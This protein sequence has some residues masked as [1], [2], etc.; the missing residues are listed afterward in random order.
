[1]SKYI[2]IKTADNSA[3][4]NTADNFRGAVHSTDLAIDLYFEAA[5]SVTGGGSYDKI[6]LVTNSN[7]EQEI[8]ESI[9]AALTGGPAKSMVVIADDVA[10]D[11]VNANITGVNAFSLATSSAPKVIPFVSITDTYEV[12][13]AQTG[14]SF[15][16]DG[17]AGKV[18]T[19][20][21]AALMGS[22]FN[23]KF[24][25]GT[26]F[27]TTDW[28]VT[29]T[30]AIGEGGIYERVNDEVSDPS[31]TGATTITFELGAET[32]GDFVELEC[33]GTKVYIN[34]AATADAAIS[35]A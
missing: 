29:F 13:P 21:S 11:Y 16:L 22:G 1:M 30:A 35:F 24:I 32:V 7:K 5:S 9:A 33:D 17:A 4:M 28:V 10:S 26:A 8:M 20:P 14:T 2:Y 3:Y 34:G 12:L 25:V 23:C 6:T 31:T 27:D 15:V 18:I 19:M